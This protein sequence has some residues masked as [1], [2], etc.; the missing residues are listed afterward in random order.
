LIRERK[1]FF[2]IGASELTEIALIALK[3]SSLGLAS[4]IDKNMIGR[5]IM[6]I[7][8]ED[9]S[10]L[11]LVNSDDI[12]IITVKVSEKKLHATIPAHVSTANIID[13]SR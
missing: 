7:V 13:L 2:F 10:S 6:G 12:V 11:K 3:D 9:Y 1:G 5:Q 4:I 8:I